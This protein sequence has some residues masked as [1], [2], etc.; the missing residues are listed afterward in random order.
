MST[1]VVQCKKMGVDMKNIIMLAIIFVFSTSVS[2]QKIDTSKKASAC[3]HNENKV[4]K[5]SKFICVKKI[6]K[7]LR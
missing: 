5:G 3:S 2:A 1:Y 6:N 4:L 7:T